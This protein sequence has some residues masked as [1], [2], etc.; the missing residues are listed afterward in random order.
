MPDDLL[1]E[2]RNLDSGYSR[3]RPIVKNAN[4]TI[5]SREIL[6]ILGGSGSGKSTLLKTM[7]GLLEPLAG[8]VTLFGTDLY[9]GRV[10]ERGALL[11][12][13]G[14]LFQR[15]ALFGSLSALDNVMF[16]VLELTDV[17]EPVARELAHA[18]LA[19]LGIGDLAGR[20]PDQVSGGQRKRVALAR[21]LI[22]DPKLVFCDEPTSGLDPAT[23]ALIDQKL[24]FIRDALGIA[25]AAVTHDIT[26]VQT[27]ADNVVVL[28]GGEVRAYGSVTEV[29]QSSDPDVYALFHRAELGERSLKNNGVSHD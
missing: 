23:A 1:L 9:G 22:L 15:E 10:E 26:S 29:E 16:P 2:C 7:A 11:R 27:I 8:S 28:A 19:Q 12:R 25:V 20:F 5:G 6:A 13:T 14:M 4:L 17:L 21:A 18:K 24:M 3:E